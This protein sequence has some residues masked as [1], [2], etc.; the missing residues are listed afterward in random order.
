VSNQIQNDAWTKL[1]EIFN[2]LDK[3][4]IAKALEEFK[5]DQICVDGITSKIYGH[6]DVEFYAFPRLLKEKLGFSTKEIDKI[7]LCVIGDCR[8]TSELYSMLNHFIGYHDVPAQ[9]IGNLVNVLKND[10]RELPSTV[11]R[12]KYNLTH[13]Q[14][15]TD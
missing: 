1:S 12:M 7:R 3:N 10:T 2:C 4:N 5:I 6:K 13:P 15:S 8:Y 14:M 11:Q 9:N